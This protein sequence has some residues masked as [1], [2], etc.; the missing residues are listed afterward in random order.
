MFARSGKSW[1]PCRY[2]C[3][4]TCG[5]LT[6]WELLAAPTILCVMVAVEHYFVQG[7][8]PGTVVLTYE[9]C[10]AFLRTSSSSFRMGCPRSDGSSQLRVRRSEKSGEQGSHEPRMRGRSRGVG[11]GSSVL[12][13]AFRL[14]RPLGDGWCPKRVLWS[15]RWAKEADERTLVLMGRPSSRRPV[16][17]S[18]PLFFRLLGQPMTYMLFS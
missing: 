9:P 12:G 13:Q 6:V 11:V 16:C 2:R 5:G 10:L 4:E 14:E 8:V 17:P 1:C 18:G 15:E 3:L 7:M